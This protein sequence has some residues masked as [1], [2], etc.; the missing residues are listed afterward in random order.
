MC[1]SRIGKSYWIQKQELFIVLEKN[2]VK[3]IGN[4][5][6]MVMFGKLVLK[7]YEIANYK[8]HVALHWTPI[9]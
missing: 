7:N 2:Y 3:E 6:N 1:G 8:T 9:Y 5:I 4:I